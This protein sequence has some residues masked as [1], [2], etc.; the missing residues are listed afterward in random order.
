MKVFTLSAALLM[1]ATIA[2]A[3]EPL[4]VGWADLA[5]P[6]TAY[7]NPFA[8][9]PSAQMARL[10]H[11]LQL[12]TLAETGTDAYAAEDAA[13]LRKELIDSGLDVDFLF[14]ERLRIMDIRMNDAVAP[15]EE[16][17][18]QK[19]R[20][21]GYLLPLDVQDGKAVEF[22]LVPS[23]GACIHTPPPPAN[24]IVYV[25]YPDGFETIGLYAPIWITGKLEADPGE[26]SLWLVDGT[27]N[28]SIT[29]KMNADA[30]L[31]YTDVN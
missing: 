9:I 21:P 12:E 28:V 20:L 15:N 3:S 5:P 1:T 14:A 16:I 8:D 10:S 18:D 29:Y 7:E 23:V 22:L 4:K 30:V 24:Q 2:G 19:V 11:L 26:K 31:D 6:Y 17:V 25:S 27:T 13:N